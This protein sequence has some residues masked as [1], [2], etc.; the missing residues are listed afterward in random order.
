MAKPRITLTTPCDST[1]AI[2]IVISGTAEASV[3]KF[4]VLAGHVKC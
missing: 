1:G 3:V 4:C 2:S